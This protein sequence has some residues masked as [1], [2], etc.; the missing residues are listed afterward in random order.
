M[1]LGFGIKLAALALL[2]MGSSLANPAHAVQFDQQE[3]NPRNFIA[4][5]APVAGGASHQLLILEQINN[6]RPCW[7]ETGSNP[8]TVEP[9]LLN[10][11]FTGIC[12]RSTD[13]NGYSVRVAGQDLASQYRLRVVRRQNDLVLVASPFGNPNSPALEIGRANGVSSDFTQIELDPGWRITRRT[14]NGQRL[15]HVYL[16]NDRDLPTLIAAATNPDPAPSRPPV[17]SQPAPT[18]PAPTQPAPTQPRPTQPLPTTPIPVPPPVTSGDDSDSPAEV[19]DYRVV[20]RAR[21]RDELAQVRVL[22]PDA[23]LITIRGRDYVQAGV[24]RDRTTA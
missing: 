7:R 14:F 10:F 20:V 11:D 18:Q 9:L 13:S 5:A 15:G 8:R 4:I 6:S 12:G 3:V 21:G 22:V 17:V 1:K 19:V 23:F 24:F 16:T 2:G